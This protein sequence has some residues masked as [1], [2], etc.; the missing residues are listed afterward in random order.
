MR[1]VFRPIKRYSE[2]VAIFRKKLKSIDFGIIG[3][4]M[5]HNLPYGMVHIPDGC[6]NTC[7]WIKQHISSKCQTKNSNFYKNF[8][9]GTI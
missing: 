2:N 5:I 7:I 6:F 9:F 4:I 1:E 3:K 8:I